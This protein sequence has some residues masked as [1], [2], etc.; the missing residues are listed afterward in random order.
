MICLPRG[1]TAYRMGVDARLEGLPVS[2]CPHPLDTV[3][4]YDWVQGWHW[5][6]EM[7]REAQ[8]Q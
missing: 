3:Q 1:G 4:A 8:P 2:A 7:L 6:E 5:A